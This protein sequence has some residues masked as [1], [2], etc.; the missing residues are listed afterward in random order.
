MKLSKLSKLSI[1]MVSILTMTS[2]SAATNGNIEVG[3][4]GTTSSG[5]VVVSIIVP[6]IVHVT[7]LEDFTF[8][9]WNGDAS[10]VLVKDFCV[11][12][13][14]SSGY[15]L[16]FDSGSGAGYS[17]SEQF[18]GTDTIGYGVEIATKSTG[19]TVGT[20]QAIP[21]GTDSFDVVTEVRTE[22]NCITGDNI[23]MRVT[24][25]NIGLALAEVGDYADV[26]SVTAIVI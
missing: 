10:P 18:G 14:S 15:N 20:Y 12:T 25:P 11:R 21:E 1:A 3:G 24:I 23:S 17:M 8:P 16:K 19:G 4:T 26:L 22:A 6:S 2:V 7:N 9:S 5:S 13:N